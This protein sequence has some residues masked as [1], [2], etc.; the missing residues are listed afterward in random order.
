MMTESGRYVAAVRFFDPVTGRRSV[1]AGPFQE[2]GIALADK[3]CS[4]LLAQAP[5]M[6]EELWTAGMALHKLEAALAEWQNHENGG[7][8]Y[9]PKAGK[10][11]YRL[12]DRGAT[13]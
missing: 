9:A 12:R 1:A 5:P 10:V 2:T 8:L 3:S 11:L 7:V 6:V 13:R 4:R